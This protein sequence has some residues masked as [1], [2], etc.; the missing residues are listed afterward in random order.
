MGATPRVRVARIGSGSLGAIR[1]WLGATSRPGLIK[2]LVLPVLIGWSMVPESLGSPSPLRPAAATLVLAALLARFSWPAVGVVVASAC[3]WFAPP[4]AVLAVALLAYGTARRTSS[5]Y[6][7]SA[8]LSASWILAVL[9]GYHRLPG[10]ADGDVLVFAALGATAAVVPAA[11]V[12]ALVGARARRLMDL[13]ERN[14]I[15][16]RANRLAES[17]A[18]MAERARIAS[19]MHDLIG[20]RLSLISLHAGALELHARNTA[21]QLSEQAVLVR[22]TAKQALDELRGVLDVLKEDVVTDDASP[23]QDGRDAGIGTRADVTGLVRASQQAGTPVELEWDG[24]DLADVDQQI[25]RTVH[26]LVRESLTNVHK[27]APGMPARVR[28]R[29]RDAELTVETSNRL[30]PPSATPAPGTRL[31][32]VGLLERVRLAGGTLTTGP[33]GDRFVVRAVLPV[34]VAPVGVSA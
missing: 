3:L 28:V 17:Q 4:A 32:L 33:D 21:P 12:G 5:P 22:T 34:T 2:V 9:G 13:K 7:A 30:A 20:H 24:D 6:W 18:R 23:G 10:A 25:R 15:L 27:H 29:R 26:R 8:A 14:E 11:A 16:R 1:A 19:E 31:G